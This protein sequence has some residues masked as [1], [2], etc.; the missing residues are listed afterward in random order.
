[1][2]NLLVVQIGP[3]TLNVGTAMDLYRIRYAKETYVHIV[4]KVSIYSVIVLFVPGAR[5]FLPGARTFLP[6][7]RTFYPPYFNLVL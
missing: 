7:A 4:N 6:C 2:A 3:N 1:M 5:T